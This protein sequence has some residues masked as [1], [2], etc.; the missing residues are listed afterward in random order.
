MHCDPLTYA[1]LP[2]ALCTAPHP[3]PLYVHCRCTAPFRLMHCV[4]LPYAHLPIALRLLYIVI[5][6]LP[7]GLCTP[8]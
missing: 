8:A 3:P 1:Q 5:A 4:P 7:I 6:Q 2:I